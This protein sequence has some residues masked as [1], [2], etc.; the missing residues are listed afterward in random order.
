[1][2]TFIP[3][4]PEIH[5][6][7][8]VEAH[9]EANLKEV[10]GL[11]PEL[12]EDVSI[13]LDNQH[14]IPETGSGGFAYAPDIMTLSFD[15]DFTDKEAWRKN[16]RGTMFHEA[17]HMVQGH[18][19]QRPVNQYKTA[20]ENGIYE[21]CGTIFEREYAGV[22]PLWGDYSQHSDEQL[23]QW[24]DSLAK[25][26]KKDYEET[27]HETYYQWAFWDPNDKQRWKMY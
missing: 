1:M 24:R 3:D 27:D 19:D 18:T 10:R 2:T 7:P 20:L 9:V 11:L 23:N 21:G 14:M 16:L 6:K 25:I 26:T 22:T 17:Y 8:L 15:P 12:P 5:L 13:W 4:A